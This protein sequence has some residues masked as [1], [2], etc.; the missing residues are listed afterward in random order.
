VTM[1]W[2]W[3]LWLEIFTSVVAAKAVFV[4]LGK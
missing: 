4:V 1:H 3:T 2:D